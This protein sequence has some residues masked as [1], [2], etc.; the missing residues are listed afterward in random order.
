M[1]IV[2]I[3]IG[4]IFFILNIVLKISPKRIVYFSLILLNLALLIYGAF[5]NN[6]I[7][8]LATLCEIVAFSSI[9]SLI[10]TKRDVNFVSTSKTVFIA[11]ISF[12]LLHVIYNVLQFGIE[13]TYSI[14][15]DTLALLNPWG[16]VSTFTFLFC[17][18]SKTALNYIDT[19][20]FRSILFFSTCAFFLLL[21]MVKLNIVAGNTSKVTENA[22]GIGLKNLSTNETALFA[23][24]NMVYFVHYI[25][26]N[27][28]KVMCLIG[29]VLNTYILFLSQ[30]RLGIIALLITILVY[31]LININKQ[32]II[33][34]IIGSIFFLLILSPLIKA[35]VE[36]FQ[37][38]STSD[39]VGRVHYSPLARKLG[40]TFSGRLLIY[41]AYLEEFFKKTEENFVL[42]YTGVGFGNLPQMF[43][44][45]FLPLLGK[46]Y[47]GRKFYPLHSDV[48]LI[49]I[50]S[51]VLG[52]S[53]WVINI[54]GGIKRNLRKKSFL[55]SAFCLILVA[56][57]LTDML[58][59]SLYASFLIGLGISY[60]ISQ[61]PK[62]FFAVV[63][64]PAPQ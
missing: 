42:L 35:F 25:K 43:T 39:L 21:I 50:T 30:S 16:I 46:S 63:D 27:K 61:P 26:L 18:N 5:S 3:L 36:V 28:G 19:I 45:S 1:D 31:I 13:N 29:I 12:I 24:C 2:K 32:Q 64:T 47:T 6:T 11:Y 7:F 10:L 4:L 38:R 14:D 53:L 48:L 49:Y 60:V 37:Q 57:S 22:G 59:Y 62:L 33:I 41:E 17:Y 15:K 23:L 55:S 9:S 34:Y 44:Q 40:T 20:Q 51:G 8:Q 54:I 52:I 58:S 56:F